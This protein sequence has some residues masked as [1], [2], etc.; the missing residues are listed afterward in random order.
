MNLN[1]NWDGSD[2]APQMLQRLVTVAHASGKKVK[3]SVGGWSG[4]K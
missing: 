1:L 3:L 2:D 4:S